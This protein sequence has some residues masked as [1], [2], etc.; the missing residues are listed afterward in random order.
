MTPICIQPKLVASLASSDAF[1]AFIGDPKLSIEKFFGFDAP[2]HPEIVRRLSSHSDPSGY[3]S[4]SRD[5]IIAL[6]RSESQMLLEEATKGLSSLKMLY[7][8]ATSP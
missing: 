2:A 5:R 8:F 3:Q 1:P 7:D 6:D 4:L